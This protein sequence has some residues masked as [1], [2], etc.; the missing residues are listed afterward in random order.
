MQRL[1]PHRPEAVF[2]ANDSMAAGALRALHEAGIRVPEDVA[3][4]GFD[5][6]PASERAVPPLTTIR[7]PVTETGARA[8]QMLNELINGE[9]QRPH[10]E[11]MPVELVVR[12]SCG[13]VVHALTA[14]SV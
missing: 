14:S 3:L 5:G 6:L 4:M 8:V 12:G 11:I 1:I 2:A 10:V 9:A 13:A 7:Q